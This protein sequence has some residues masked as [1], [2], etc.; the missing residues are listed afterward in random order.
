MALPKLAIIHTTPVTVD[1]LKA[2]AAEFMPG[3]DLINFVDDSILP[4]LIQNEGMTETV[5]ERWLT[6]AKFAEQQGAAYIVS[7]CSSVGEVA[8]MAR[9]VVQVPVL[10]IDEAMAEEA[11]RSG[12]R[13]G[14][15]ATL[16][17]TLQP[18]ISLIESKA[19]QQGREIEIKSA[20]A[21]EA[22]RLLM[23]GDKEGH[24]RVL[25][26]VLLNLVKSVDVVVLAQASMARV[27]ASLPEELQPKFLASPRIGIAHIAQIA[28]GDRRVR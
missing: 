4:E 1:P 26:E 15:A 25:A 13:I 21:A 23:N 3:W 22:Y 24:D 27:V 5:I 9:Q 18:T 11:V 19:G 17:T 8:S 7:A 20:L 28:A 6:Y 10:R 2:L 16:S 12:R 14:V